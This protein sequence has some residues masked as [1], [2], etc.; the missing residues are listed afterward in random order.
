MNNHQP[1]FKFFDGHNDV[2]AR[3]W[4]S[5][6]DDPVG[7]FLEGGLPSHIDLPRCKKANLLGGLFA[8]FVPPIQYLQKTKSHRLTD[9]FDPNAEAYTEQDHQTIV[10]AQL[11]IL[12]EIVERA[13]AKVQLCRSF[14]EINDCQQKGHFAI[15]LHLEGAECIVSNLE[16]LDHLYQ[17]GLR[18]VGPL[19]NLPNRW[20]H[21]L[22]KGFPASPDTG[23]G[24]TDAGKVLV[25]QCRRK[26]LLV[27]CSHMNER[28][29]WDTAD[30]GG[31]LIATH[32]NAHKICP[33]SRNLTDD[34]LR[35]I[36]QSGGLVG[37]NFGNAFLRPDGEEN[38]DTFIDL[39]VEHLEYMV[40]LAGPD[41]V[42]LG[43]D[44]DGTNVPDAIGDVTGLQ[45]L[46]EHLVN[47]GWSGELISKVC[48]QNWLNALS[49]V[50][51]S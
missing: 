37:L 4:L 13:P 46:A 40:D 20:G 5:D 43:S 16:F 11:N 51:Q 25:S 26:G 3:L 35:A 30:I 45:T 10:T 38:A 49:R 23:P 14:A 19:W 48:H 50:W 22:G 18:S 33:R 1:P 47:R 41:H 28:A 12:K 31:R 44:F 29:F 6:A 36:G 21:G 32:S 39:M 17:A 34:Q 24:L 15:V 7:L 2:L 8:L 9:L 42:A 27:D